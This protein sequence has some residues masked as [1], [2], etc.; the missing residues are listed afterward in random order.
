MSQE[1]PH[2]HPITGPD[3][4]ATHCSPTCLGEPCR[5]RIYQWAQSLLL[6]ADD[7]EDI[8]QEVCVRCLLGQRRALDEGAFA[9]WLRRATVDTA[10]AMV[11]AGTVDG[12]TTGTAL[13]LEPIATGALSSP[14]PR[15]ETEAWVE[16]VHAALAQLTPRQSQLLQARYVDGCSDAEI[17]A[18]LGDT[19]QV[20]RSSLHRARKQFRQAF[21]TAVAEEG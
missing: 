17:A 18:R 7:A 3:R 8:A 21:T 5:Q 2:S 19:E 11:R 6:D 4:T 15:D 14:A 20:V 13:T 12:E 10:S 16:G 1:S 9:A